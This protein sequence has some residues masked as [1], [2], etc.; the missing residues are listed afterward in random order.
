VT[1]DG[2]TQPGSSTNT[3]LFGDNA[4]IDIELSGTDLL[5]TNDPNSYLVTNRN[6]LTIQTDNCV[7][8]GLNIEQLM[9]IINFTNPA[10]GILIE[11]GSSNTIEGNFIGT[12]PTGS[13]GRPN[14]EGVTVLGGSANLIG[15]TNTDARNIIACDHRDVHLSNTF[16]NVIEGN[17]VD[18]P[19]RSPAAFPRGV[20]D[21]DILI[22]AASFNNLVGGVIVPARNYI[23]AGP[24]A[25]VEMD[26]SMTNQIFGNWIGV[27]PPNPTPFGTGN[28]VGV[29]LSN[30]WD[31]AIGGVLAGQGNVISGS[32]GS[33]YPGPGAGIWLSGPQSSNNT[34][35]ANF[36]GTGPSGTNAMANSIG[37]VL[38]TG[39]S[40]NLIGGTVAAA[41]N[42]ISG[43]F[44]EGL[45]LGANNVQSNL[46]QGNYIGSDV[47]GTNDLHNTDGVLILSGASQNLIG[48]AAPG[49]GNLISGNTNDGLIISGAASNLVQGNL[50][51]PDIT[52][53]EVLAGRSAFIT[54]FYQA[55]GVVISNGAGHNVIGGLA[56]GERNVI[57]GNLVYGV[58][59]QEPNTS[60][61]FL[62][63]NYIGIDVLGKNPLGNIVAGVSL[64]ANGNFLNGTNVI[65]ANPIGIEITGESNYVATNFV[66]TDFSGLAALANGTDGIDLDG[67]SSACDSNLLAQ[68][69]VSGNTNY[70]VNIFGPAATNNLLVGNLIG[71]ALGGTN[72]LPNG[73]AGVLIQSGPNT[74]GGLGAGQS[75]LISGNTGPGVELDQASGITVLGNRIGVTMTGA[76][77]LPNTGDGIYAFFAPSNFI[78]LSSSG[79]NLI[80]GNL[81]YGLHLDSSDTNLIEA[82]FVGPDATG[83][84]A[85]G[86]ALGGMEIDYSAGNQITA[87][88]LISGNPSNGLTLY[89]SSQNLI[90]GCLIGV[91]KTGNSALANSG[92]GISL[93]DTSAS[94]LIGGAS[95]GLG[96]LI[97]G[98]ASNGVYLQGAGAEG[99][100]LVGNYIGTDASGLHPVPNLGQGIDIGGDLVSDAQSNI[101]GGYS[102]G[103]GNLIAFN[104]QNGVRVFF[105]ATDNTIVGNSMHDNGGLGINLQPYGEPDNT[106]TPNHP[107]GGTIGPNELVNFPVLT[108]VSFSG[109]NTLVS[110]VIAQGLTNQLFSVEFYRNLMPDP[111]GYGEGQFYLGRLFVTTDGSGNASF[112]FSTPGNLLAQYFSATATEQAYGST[113]E[114]SASLA[115]SPP[116][117]DILSEQLSGGL[118]SFTFQTVNGQSYT[119]QRNDNLA[120][121]NWVYDTNFTGNGSLT[122]VV[123][124]LTNVPQ[125]FFRVREP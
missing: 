1:I 73:L 27:T 51:G 45:I 106:V 88:N 93:M 19:A 15:G 114:F 64:A 43:N 68:N 91:N 32:G 90:Q 48:G 69:L 54:N 85:L 81:G 87:G 59:L 28:G 22:E 36:I 12:D 116:P 20:T 111:S 21:I 115:G 105:N 123:T 46:V 47:T 76:S 103:A 6:G 125:R 53:E 61:N 25:G 18:V 104:Q 37:L 124:V 34:I 35:Q 107:G 77:A 117:V 80:S 60:G 99:N 121:T 70:G 9:Q 96:N 40:S 30:S 62:Q 74:I 75:N 67:T 66:G 92:S 94:N 50:L 78:G 97:S 89:G 16:L 71:P 56:P 65:S 26:N 101:V 58:A 17:F 11:G 55:N 42:L 23:V 33:L 72:A 100:L 119:V 98:N 5:T 29:R 120:T 3:E 112:N 7:I 4:V 38:D 31:I 41:R 109:G 113:S 102:A 108:N 84:N 52:S 49:A 86:N 10:V 39:A 122:Q 83:T 8:R 118:F 14:G 44:N 110:G 57:S 2:Y 13:T 63:G 24:V 79:G 82:N 95:P